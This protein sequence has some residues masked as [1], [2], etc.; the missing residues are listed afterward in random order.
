M[1]TIFSLAA[2]NDEIDTALF[3]TEGEITPAIQAL[4][5]T[6]QHLEADKVDAYG[7]VYLDHVEKSAA[8]LRLAAELTARAKQHE[9]IAEGRKRLMQ[10]Y[11]ER[12]NVREMQ[13]TFARF[14]RT[15]NGGAQKVELI[16]PSETVPDAYRKPIPPSPQRGDVDVNALR[17]ALLVGRKD[18]TAVAK[19]L[20]RT[21]RLDVSFGPRQ[22]V[23]SGAGLVACGVLDGDTDDG[24]ALP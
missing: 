13:G 14:H 11:M 21:E 10:W 18:A 5:D 6:H 12:R 19:L 7:I 8:C 20:P 17:T 2:L 4:L 23:S 1:P 24:T 9:K 22:R 15:I 16:V 3:D